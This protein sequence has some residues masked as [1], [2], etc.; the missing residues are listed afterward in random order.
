MER[1]LERRSDT[2]LSEEL[3]FGGRSWWRRRLQLGGGRSL[4]RSER[5]GSVHYVED[6]PDMVFI[7]I[8]EWGRSRGDEGGIYTDSKLEVWVWDGG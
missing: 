2:A 3:Q 8:K 7:G 5:V 6:R 4:L 1:L